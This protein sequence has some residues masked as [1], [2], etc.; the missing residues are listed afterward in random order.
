MTVRNPD[1]T[2]LAD[3]L[4]A[5]RRTSEP[6]DGARFEAALRSEADCYAVQ[7]RVAEALGPVG[8]FKTARKPDQPQ[9]I[10]PIFARDVHRSPASFG[11]GALR[12]I[13]VELEVGF[14]VI[15]PLP[16]PAVPDFAARTRDRVA[17]VAVLEIVDTRLADLD[18]AG[19]LLRLADNQLNGAL[20]IGE[21]RADWQDLDLATVTA[22]LTLGDETVLDGPAFPPGGNAWETFLGFARMVATHCGGLREGQVVITGSL[23]GLPFIDRPSSARGAIEALGTVEAVFP[24]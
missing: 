16:D 17:A 4:I 15:A 11:P 21:P 23:N 22:K 1:W 9:I 14:L 19:R 12:R 20:V 10:A 18:G 7:T 5:A 24:D 6:V 2:D 3:A 8:A 13:G